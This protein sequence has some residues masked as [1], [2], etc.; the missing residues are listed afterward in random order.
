MKLNESTNQYWGYVAPA[1]SALGRL[2]DGVSVQSKRGQLWLWLEGARK[3]ILGD[4]L[5]E[6]ARATS[7]GLLGLTAAVG[8]AIVALA[9][10]QSW[11]LIAG[12]SIPPIPTLHQDVGKASVA[13]GVA[14]DTG[15]QGGSRADGDGGAK[16][17]R[18][19]S[20][21]GGGGDSPDADSAPAES[22][23]LVVSPSTPAKPTGE[24]EGGG[25][26]QREPAP[27]T[28][29]EQTP[30]APSGAALPAVPVSSPQPPATETPTAV[31]PAT[32][33]GAPD[34]SS[35][36][37]WSNGNGNG[38]AYGRDDWDDDDHE[39]DDHD[40]DWDDHDWDDDDHDW[41]DDDRD[42]DGHGRH[43]DHD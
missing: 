26:D 43:H 10:N 11:P 40:R 17:V 31:P 29:P 15:A 5:L 36:P 38:H 8:L 6:R 37:P 22:T 4:G 35:A 42:W 33:S 28:Q 41:D 34:E 1:L 7:L 21:S 3:A 25:S 30:K 27:A 18:E 24:D 13:A 16:D 23:D 20:G 12:S 9:L 19:T 2:A 14:D 39:W 32:A